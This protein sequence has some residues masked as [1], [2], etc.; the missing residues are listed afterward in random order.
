MSEYLGPDDFRV[1]VRTLPR[2]LDDAKLVQSMRHVTQDVC[3][4]WLMAF[5]GNIAHLKEAALRL[6][7]TDAPSQPT[8]TSSAPAVHQHAALPPERLTA[9]MAQTDETHARMVA[10][11]TTSRMFPCQKSPSVPDGD[12]FTGRW[13]NTG[14]ELS[15]EPSTG[16]APIFF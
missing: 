10:P 16:K 13:E 7:A 14:K 3:D 11:C 9:A 2:P 5:G 1:W 12:F 15:M 8:V 6:A 4:G